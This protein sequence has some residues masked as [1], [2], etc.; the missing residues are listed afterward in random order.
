[1]QDFLMRLPTEV[2]NLV[3]PSP[4]PLVT[5]RIIQRSRSSARAFYMTDSQTAVASHCVT[6]EV[7]LSSDFIV[8]LCQ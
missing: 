3:T 2:D 1:M 6:N 8:N 7:R 4:R 5:S